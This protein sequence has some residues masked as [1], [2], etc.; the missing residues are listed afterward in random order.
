MMS[1]LESADYSSVSNRKTEA[2]FVIFDQENTSLP[3]PLPRPFTPRTST[4]QGRD[5]V[6]S[7]YKVFLFINNI[8]PIVKALVIG[9]HAITR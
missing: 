7:E 5:L 4:P 6:I 2:I 8:R 1:K 9:G 3:T